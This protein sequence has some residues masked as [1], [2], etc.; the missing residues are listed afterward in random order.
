[1]TTQPAIPRTA[2]RRTPRAALWVCQQGGFSPFLFGLVVGM[3]VFSALSMQWAKQ[4]LVRYEEQQARRAQ[5]N[6]EE[7]AKGLEFAILTEDQSSY[8]ENYDLERAKA[9]A[10]TDARTRGGQDYLLTTHENEQR[11]VF[12]KKDTTIAIT[13]SDDTLLRSQIY[14]TADS[15][16]VLRMK[17]GSKQA[18]AIYDT[19]QARDRQVRTSNERMEQLAE[20]L[21]AF[22]AGQRRFPTDSEFTRLQGGL[23]LHD[24]WGE[25][26]TY[27]AKPDGQTGTLSFTTPWNY[28]QTLKLSLQE[29]GIASESSDED[30]EPQRAS[31]ADGQTTSTNTG[32]GND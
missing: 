22:Y 12:G 6:A 28:T 25:D 17:T 27:T 30:A 19:G 18:V 5:S 32:P 9:F 16:E 4:E 1:M 26:F 15:E 24:A 31:Q 11:E 21:Y 14:R 23:D 8:S 3:S 20:Q 2:R 7:V 29:D 10:E 13:G